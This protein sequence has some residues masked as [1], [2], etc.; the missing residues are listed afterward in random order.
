MVPKE[1]GT[2]LPTL[3]RLRECVRVCVPVPF[4]SLLCWGAVPKIDQPTNK[5]AAK[6]DPFGSS[7]VWCLA[8]PAEVQDYYVIRILLLLAI[9]GESGDR[10]RV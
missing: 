2:E 8:R 6:E 4:R 7:F 3:I 10:D 9:V 5:E 1:N